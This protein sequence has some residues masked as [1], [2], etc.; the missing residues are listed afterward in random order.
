MDALGTTATTT[1]F[2][3]ARTAGHLPANFHSETEFS[4]GHTETGSGGIADAVANEAFTISYVS[5]D[6]AQPIGV[7]PHV[8]SPTANIQ[9]DASVSSGVKK[10]I[11]PGINTAKQIMIA[12][13]APTTSDPAT[14]G[15]DGINPNPT[16]NVA[17]PIGGFTWMYV[18]TCYTSQTAVNDMRQAG[19][20]LLNYM[21]GP[22]ADVTTILNA[23]GFSALPGSWKNAVKDFYVAA[24][25]DS[26]N[27]R[28]RKAPSAGVCTTGATAF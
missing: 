23:H 16:G 14:W 15:T 27:T 17:Y 26:V 8:A 20:G 9:N 10:F 1:Y 2:T 4:T 5:T 7:A 25:A 3:A 19:F 28:I 24:T 22:S 18:Y 12:Q 13:P 11:P 6:Y 21:Y